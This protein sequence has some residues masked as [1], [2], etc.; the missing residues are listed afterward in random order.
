[1]EKIRESPALTFQ[2][3]IRTEEGDRLFFSNPKEVIIARHLDEVIPALKKV[4][5]FAKQGYYAGGFISYE[6]APAFEEAYIVHKNKELPLLWFGIFNEPQYI[7]NKVEKDYQISSWEPAITYET[8]QRNIEAIKDAI[9][10]GETYQV[11]YTMRLRAKFQGDYLS[12]YNYLSEN[13]QASYSA[14]LDIGSYKILSASPELFFHWKNNKIVTKPMK[15]TIKRGRWAEEDQGNSVWLQESEKNRAENL[16]IVDL[17][18]NDLGRIAVPGTVK[19]TNL[20]EVE[21]YPTV[22]QMT[23][24]VT[25]EPREDVQLLDIIKNLFPCGSI[26]GAPKVSTMKHIA[27]L[28]DEPREIYCGTIGLI[29]PSESVF[30]V[31]IRTM[32]INEKTGIAEYS[33]GGGITWDSTTQDEYSEALSKAALLTERKVQPFH[34]VETLLLDNGSYYLFDR[35]IDRLLSSSHYF[36]FN[37]SKKDIVNV[38]MNYSK[39]NEVGLFRVRLLV[40]K[41]GQIT[42]EGRKMDQSLNHPLTF[43]ISKEPINKYDRFLYHKTSIRDIYDYHRRQN[44]SVFDVLLWNEDGQIT[45][46]TTGNIV[47]EFDGK[48]YTP[49]KESGL[50]PGTLRGKLLSDGTLTERSI[51]LNEI[52]QASRIYFINSV[53][54]MQEIQCVQ[55][56]VMSLN[57]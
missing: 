4:Q 56:E 44:N 13:Q 51:L 34:L 50:L 41:K 11:N 18:R 39:S 3:P 8:F 23:S 14:F 53:R 17:L 27:E 40:S 47:L 52:P 30:N 24:T 16:M 31:A 43:S 54:G 49:L 46:F 45:E 32:F 22:F 57:V 38:L 19:V 55:S 5:E 36:G 10:F 28:E 15:G 2:F 26:T 42:I 6:A 35:H 9:S 20:F 37:I 29:T 25:A 7:N 12:F 33:V 48:L 1:M 21:R